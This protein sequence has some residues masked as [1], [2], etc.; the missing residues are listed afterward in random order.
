MAQF[1]V[2]IGPLLNAIELRKEAMITNRLQEELKT[3]DKA[4]AAS[5]YIHETIYCDDKIICDG[6]I[7]TLD[8]L[9]YKL[10]KLY[11]TT[12]TTV[13]A[14]KTKPKRITQHTVTRIPYE[15]CAKECCPCL[16]GIK[17]L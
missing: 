3:L 8:P 6:D 15:Q 13:P 2:N 16:H 11:A 1:V 17:M 14:T 9:K 10:F 5:N 4:S 12:T 7:G